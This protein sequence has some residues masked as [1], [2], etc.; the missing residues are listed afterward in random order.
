M[1]AQD[2]QYA[3]FLADFA[4]GTLSPGELLAAQLHFALSETGV[5]SRWVLDAT[6]GALLEGV[7]P[8]DLIA[9]SDS[10]VARSDTGGAGDGGQDDST[11][12]NWVDFYSHENLIAQRWRT[13]LFGVKT[14]KTHLS[15]ASLLRM[16]PGERAPRHSHSGPDVTVVLRGA[17]A[18]DAGEYHRGDLAFADAG[19]KHAP[20][21]IGDEIC[22]CLI[23]TP[24]GRPAVDVRA[25]LAEWWK[26]KGEQH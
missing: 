17:F 11:Q 20:A 13:S 19:D 4:A 21:T 18:D 5:Q 3:A 10:A 16:D 14:L 15:S 2:N 23:A 8:L 6:G 12:T 7:A 24:A 25:L 22:I 9:K 26:R 1:I